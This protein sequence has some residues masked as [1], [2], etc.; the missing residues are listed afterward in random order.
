MEKKIISSHYYFL[1]KNLAL[2]F[3]RLAKA[4]MTLELKSTKFLMRLFSIDSI[5][6]ALSLTSDIVFLKNVLTHLKNTFLLQK[7]TLVLSLEASKALLF[8]R[9][10]LQ[11]CFRP[12]IEVMQQLNSNCETLVG[13]ITLKAQISVLLHLG[14]GM[15]QWHFSKYLI[16]SIAHNLKRSHFLIM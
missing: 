5:A 12:E 10:Y 1:Y 15:T 3:L 7:K 4:F 9:R 6:K 13:Y 11:G 14:K 2:L 8:Q 16:G